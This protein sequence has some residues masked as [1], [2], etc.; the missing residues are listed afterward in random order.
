MELNKL[1]LSIVIL[2]W[3]I[4]VNGQ[5]DTLTNK[6]LNDSLNI[7]VLKEIGNKPSLI[8]LSFFK[9]HKLLRR[10]YAV[11]LIRETKFIVKNTKNILTPNTNLLKN[12]DSI[13]FCFK[14][15]KDAFL[16]DKS[17]F[18]K[19]IHGGNIVFGMISNYNKEK[20]D[21]NSDNESYFEENHESYLYDIIKMTLRDQT[22]VTQNR[23][24]YCVIKSNITGVVN[25]KYEFK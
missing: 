10:G 9:D 23:L 11:F 17:I 24:I 21:Y 12:N 22:H 2:L 6:S 13:Q 5:R 14:Y 4:I 15:K 3:P 19:F 16:T 25:F 1:V 20:D 7:E 8:T 18:K